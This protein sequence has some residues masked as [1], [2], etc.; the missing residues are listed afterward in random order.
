MADSSDKAP[1]TVK[2]MLPF[3]FQTLHFLSSSLFTFHLFLLV[4][5]D[6]C[7]DNMGEL[8]A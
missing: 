6:Y 3:I 8:S 2:I 7:Y 4:L 5:Y 1:Q